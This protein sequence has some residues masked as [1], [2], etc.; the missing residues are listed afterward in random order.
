MIYLL[1][2]FGNELT[3]FP[4]GTN[5]LVAVKSVSKSK[6]NDKLLKKLYEEIETLQQLK[7]PHIVA[8][9]NHTET[10]THVHLVM[11]YCNLGDLSDFIRK[12]AKHHTNPAVLDM[13]QKYPHPGRGGLNEV[14]SRHFLKQIVSALEFL[15]KGF[16]EEA[17]TRSTREGRQVGKQEPFIH[18]DIKPQNLLLLPSPQ[19]MQQ[20]P[21]EP[22]LE[23]SAH[24]S[25]F[26]AAG[27]SSLPMLKL[28]DFGFARALPKTSLAETLC[29]SPLY[30]APEILRYEKYN[31]KVD[32]WSVGTVMYEMV[33]GEPPFR[34]GNHVELLKKIERTEDRIPWDPAISVSDDMRSLINALL[35]KNPTNRMEFE[36]LWHHPAVLSEI[37]N[38]RPEDKPREVRRSPRESLRV[39]QAPMMA[40]I[41]SLRETRKNMSEQ[42]Q[43]PPDMSLTPSNRAQR[44]FSSEV[45]EAT[46]E[47]PSYG[48]P[49]RAQTERFDR[50]PP[51]GSR[52]ESLP[53]R[54]PNMMPSAT[55]PYG[56]VPTA[57]DMVRHRSQE[58]APPGPGSSLLNEKRGARTSQRRDDGSMTKEERD[59][60]LQDVKDE[61]EYVVVEKRYVEV[62]AFADELHQHARGSGQPHSAPTPR[63][64]PSNSRRST[65]GDARTT[66][67]NET[68]ASPSS[69][70]NMQVAAKNQPRQKPSYEMVRPRPISATSAITKAIGNA[71]LR[72]FGIS[73]YTPAMFK[74]SPPLPQ[75]IF[76]GSISASPKI[77]GQHMISYDKTRSRGN[78]GTTADEKLAD[79]MDRLMERVDLV[80]QFA[81]VKWIQL[82]PLQ[83]SVT[84]AIGGK[85]LEN[86]EAGDEGLDL[87]PDA[88][89]DVS[90]EAYVLY[91]KVLELLNK[92]IQGVETWW[93]RKKAQDIGKRQSQRDLAAAGEINTKVQGMRVKFNEAL[94]RAMVCQTRF[95]KAAQELKDEERKPV[96]EQPIHWDLIRRT[97][98]EEGGEEEEEERVL[99]AGASADD[100]VYGGA[101]DICITAGKAQQIVERAFEN[102]MEEHVSL[103]AR[104][105]RPLLSEDAVSLK[106]L[107][108]ANMGLQYLSIAPPPDYADLHPEVQGR[109]LDEVLE[110]AIKDVLEPIVTR[111]VVKVVDDEVAQGR[112]SIATYTSS[113][114]V[115]DEKAL[116]RLREVGE[117]Y[118]SSLPF[119]YEVMEGSAEMDEKDSTAGA[120]RM[121]IARSSKLS[122]SW[123]FMTSKLTLCSGSKS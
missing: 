103:A 104:Q 20:H 37:P 56:R 59:R 102:G 14:V 31:G 60:A 29:G 117:T 76:P 62:N 16:N 23:T 5:S 68:L 109:V 34:A 119:F 47:R 74:Q 96:D 9:L 116:S 66:L 49:P 46:R 110:K 25:S 81:E 21:E 115:Y 42:A 92:G 122:G 11:E 13:V 83:P 107:G 108:V 86:M 48:T 52:G 105:I 114:P 67:A 61:R 71:S 6:L 3:C 123:T 58:T 57:V 28:A 120:E 40:R 118:L 38:L 19:Y 75:G 27:L 69:P 77:G 1:R 54:R 53:T 32:L 41:P 18:R 44:A 2:F 33:T 85:V 65:A 99:G 121:D 89:I 97:A 45:P 63:Y 73:G 10:T 26:P 79:D 84:T 50:G 30:M 12:R 113:L 91:I 80:H 72:L 64:R 90:E 111:I 8:L 82:M 100:L 106:R 93:T 112:L 78:S 17:L 7:H 70:I 15:Q 36:E 95:E 94:E 55:A 98:N 39:E 87:T 101:M 4:Q 24:E 88:V 43:R 22:K 51:S 35:R